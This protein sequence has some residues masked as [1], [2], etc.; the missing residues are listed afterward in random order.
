MKKGDTTK[1]QFYEDQDFWGSQWDEDHMEWFGRDQWFYADHPY[2]VEVTNARST[3]TIGLK[4]LYFNSFIVEDVPR[5]TFK[6][7]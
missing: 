6:V 7:I 3:K 4:F 5:E 2:A 1:I